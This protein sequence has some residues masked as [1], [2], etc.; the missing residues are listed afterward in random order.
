MGAKNQIMSFS[1]SVAIRSVRANDFLNRTL[2]SLRNQTVLP[3][4]IVIVIPEGVSPWDTDFSNVRFVNSVRG[5]VAQRSAGIHAAQEKYVLL[6]DDDVVLSPNMSDVLLTNMCRCDAACIIPYWPEGWPR[7][8]FVKMF[9]S[10]WGIAIPQ[11]SGGIGYTAGG[12]YFYPCQEPTI[13]WETLGGA[14]AVILVDRDFCVEHGC[15]GDMALQAISVYAL[16]EDAAFIFDIFQKGGKCFMVGGASFEHLGGTT[17]LDPL[18]LSMSYKAQVVNHYLFWSKY[19]YPHYNCKFV[20]RFKAKFS[21][22]RYMLGIALLATIVSIR[23][24]TIQPVVG[25]CLGV[26]HLFNAAR[27]NI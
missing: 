20:D 6:L 12:G 2:E 10:V 23:M 7:K 5:M 25:V 19:I 21:F 24:M 1:Y 3:D 15:F 13:P 14:G 4:E 16:R 26:K 18:R 8:P 11:K 9:M 17:R 27:N 22:A